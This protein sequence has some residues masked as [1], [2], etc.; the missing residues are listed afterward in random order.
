MRSVNFR[1]AGR[2][3]I[4]LVSTGPLATLPFGMGVTTACF[5][6]L[7]ILAVMRLELT[8]LSSERPTQKLFL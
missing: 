6:E 2:I 3:E 8:T 7:G 4:G 1:M 5:H